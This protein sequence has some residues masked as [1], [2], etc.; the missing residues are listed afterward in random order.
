MG[1]QRRPSGQPT[2]L[3]DR[4]WQSE[5]TDA[6]EHEHR[7]T[8]PPLSRTRVG[9]AMTPGRPGTLKLQQ[10]FGAPLLLVRYRYDWTGLYRYTTV[11]LL[12]DM[13][14]VTRGLRPQTLYVVRLGRY[15]QHLKSQ[16]RKMGAAWDAGLLRWTLP[17][18]AVQALNLV[19]RVEWVQATDAPRRPTPQSANEP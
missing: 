5:T 8:M 11:E 7:L 17:G 9:K 10:R 19:H 6:H 3:P 18:H 15:E 4:T 13:S 16:A 14:P 1:L 12:M 2:P